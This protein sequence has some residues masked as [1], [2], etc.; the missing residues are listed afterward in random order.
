MGKEQKL[1]AFHYVIFVILAAK[2]HIFLFKV[3]ISKIKWHII[4][5]SCEVYNFC[6]INFYIVRIPKLI[7]WLYQLELS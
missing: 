2:Y 3:V 4:F 7:L 5:L 1:S 6:N